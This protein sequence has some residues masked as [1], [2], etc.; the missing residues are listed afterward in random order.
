[1]KTLDLNSFGIEEMNEVELRSVEGGGFFQSI[2]N[3]FT[4]IWKEGFV[5]FF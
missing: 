1:M 3:F 4:H 2:G 5:W